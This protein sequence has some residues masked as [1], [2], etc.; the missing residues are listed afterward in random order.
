MDEFV[1]ASMSVQKQFF[2]CLT[3]KAYVSNI[4]RRLL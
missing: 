2:D 4:A 3:A 1:T